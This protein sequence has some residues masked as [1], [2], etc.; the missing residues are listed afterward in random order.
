V[1][2]KLR[3]K[4]VFFWLVFALVLCFFAV[5][6]FAAGETT[7]SGISTTGNL[8]FDGTQSQW[9]EA[10][11]REAY[12]LGLTY[13]QV[14]QNYQRPITREEF[15]V[16][17]VKLYE[18]L[19]GTIAIPG[20]NPFVDTTN[21]EILKAY[22]VRIVNGTS[23]NTFS[24]SASITRQEICC[25]ILNALKA[26][27]PNLDASPGSDFPFNDAGEV[28][29]WALNSMKFAYRN[30][31]MRGTAA[32]IISP[33]SNT[34]REQAVILLKRTYSKYVGNMSVPEQGALL[35]NLDINDL[36]AKMQ[37]H[38]FTRDPQANNNNIHPSFSANASG[39]VS[40]TPITGLGI[41]GDLQPNI[42][43]PSLGE[44]S[45]A[46]DELPSGF[47]LK[48]S[49]YDLAGIDYL[50]RGYN[51]ITGKYADGNSVN[52][53]VLSIN[54]LLNSKRVYK[55][56]ASASDS[57]FVRG[58]SVHKYA[59]HM[60]T[61]IGVSGGYL[62]FSGSV[63]TNFS[64][65]SLTETNRQYATL[66]YEAP[67]YCVYFDD[68]NLNFSDFLD[69]AFKQAVNDPNVKPAELFEFYGT[70]VLRSVRMG[71]RL[72]YNATANSTY[73]SQ[74]HNFEQDVKASFNALFASAGVNVQ[75][76]SSTTSEAFT[77]H[78]ETKIKAYP[79]YGAGDFNPAAFQQWFNSL[80]T[81]PGISDFGPRPLIPIYELASTPARRQQLKLGYEEYAANHQYIPAAVVHCI[82][83]IRLHAYTVADALSNNIPAVYV[84][85]TTGQTWKLV[86]NI[87]PHMMQPGDT[88]Q[89]IYVR[90]GASDNAQNPPV[91][92][93][94]L[95]NETQGENAQT[96]FKHFWG[97]DPTARLWGVGA[98]LP[99]NSGL[100]NYVSALPVGDKLKLYYVTSTNE[101]PITQLRVRHIGR[102]GKTY[103]FPSNTEMD[104]SFIPVFDRGSI[105]KGEFKPQDCAEGTPDSFGLFGLHRFTFLEYSYE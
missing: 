29:S 4:F 48:P 90:E 46:L 104:S 21:P 22:A 16:I 44:G 36:Y 53:Y 26:A 83:G 71:G 64:S 33:L 68:R 66:I 63:T 95:V 5:P 62:F 19:S 10:D 6:V 76:S 80:Q 37:E 18:K 1:L 31:I 61:S 32:G 88:L 65:S 59:E 9:A 23:A 78:C 69:P 86:S 12:S 74:S 81:K 97:N 13:D 73:N 51:I 57:R 14:E 72:E 35:E 17:A 89:H 103:Y 87:S 3:K 24:P 85:P 38:T 20:N 43:T 30:E 7:M 40:V 92:A 27:Q 102:D 96:I 82:T 99:P 77:Q 34:T 49:E 42:G 55:L 101:R 79:A 91:V 70:H 41:I 15:C 93:V 25:M 84:D 47:P 11:L 52:D 2:T 8:N 28:A 75:N 45:S 56:D 100:Q 98:E 58:S 94:F 54:K 60:A 39:G 67:Q 50:G 105:M